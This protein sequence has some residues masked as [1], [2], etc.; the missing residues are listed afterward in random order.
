MYIICMIIFLYANSKVRD[1]LQTELIAIFPDLDIYLQ[2]YSIM[3]KFSKDVN[4]N[5]KIH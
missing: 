5:L 4:V 2:L 1:L 3:R